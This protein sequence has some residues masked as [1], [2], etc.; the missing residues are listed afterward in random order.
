MLHIYSGNGKGKTTAGF[1]LVLRQTG[2]ERRVAVAQFLKDGTSGELR[3]LQALSCVKVRATRMPHGFYFQ[4]QEQEQLETRQGIQE[5][6]AWVKDRAKECT[7]IFLDE[8]LDAVQLG[9]LKEGELLHFL[10]EH[11]DLEIILTGRNPSQELLDIC[12][13]HTEMVEHRHPYQKGIAARKGVE[14]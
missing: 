9:L 6:F 10:Q 12:D 3:A 14:Y 13:Y 1:G 11:R 2:Y 7:C 5:L 8:V 4:M